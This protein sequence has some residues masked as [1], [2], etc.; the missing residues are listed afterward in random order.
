[1]QPHSP[2]IGAV[3][4]KVARCGRGA[5]PLFQAMHGLKRP[6]HEVAAG[7]LTWPEVR[8]AY[9]ANLALVWDA[10]RMLAAALPEKRFVVTSDHGEML[11]EDGGKFGHECNWRN[12]ELFQV[13]WLEATGAQIAGA[14]Q[15]TVINKLEALGYA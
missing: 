2:Y 6:D 9:L 7:R 10:V 4:M 1:M 15:D 8:E 14:E 12:E 3:P 5:H 11:G 13:P